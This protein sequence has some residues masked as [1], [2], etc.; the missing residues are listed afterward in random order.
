VRLGHFQQ[1]SFNCLG[2][3][4]GTEAATLDVDSAFRCCPILPSQ[5][6]NFVI[7]WNDRYYVDHDAPFG[8]TSAGGV[9]GR[10]ADAKSEIL[11]SKGIGPSKNWVDD[12]VFFRFPI[13][14]IPTP[15]FSYSLTDIYALAKHLGWPWKE[16]K[17]RP[18]STEFK[19]LGFIWNLMT[20]TVQ[21]PEQKKLR[22]VEKLK[23]WQNGRKFIKKDVESLLGTLVH[24]SLAVPDGRSHLP[25]LSCFATSFNFLPSPFIWKTPNP[26]V[27]AD[28]S[29]WRTHLSADFCG[30]TLSKPPPTFPVEFWVDTSS[31]WGVGIVFGDEWE[32]W[33]FSTDWDTDG[34]NIGWAE[35][36]A[37]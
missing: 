24:C 30:S 25:S 36:I 11:K 13:L 31:S 4:D 1:Y 8:A 21:I 35:I 15:L 16:S 17:T 22:Y 3:P 37:I 32:S 14:L 23:P 18:F 9:F 27:L 2:C 12:F 34:R 7:H 26:S 10:V 19:Y 29:W 33:E 20:K 6:R 5:Q 28:I